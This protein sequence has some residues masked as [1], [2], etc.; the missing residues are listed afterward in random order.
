MTK[1]EDTI[2]QITKENNTEDS[3]SKA[4]QLLKMKEL[5]DQ[6]ILTEEEFAKIKKDILQ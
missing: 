4:E 5:L 3:L 2:Q 6:G 1:L